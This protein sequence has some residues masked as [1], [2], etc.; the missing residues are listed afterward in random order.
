MSYLRSIFCFR[1][2]TG[3]THIKKMLMENK[4]LKHLNIDSNNKTGDDGV[5]HIAEG[6]R[7]N[8]TLTEL[9][10]QYCEISAKGI[11]GWL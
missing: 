2:Y 11:N 1:S 6:L 10:L 5:R 9:L 7:Q 3:A 4:K 8:D